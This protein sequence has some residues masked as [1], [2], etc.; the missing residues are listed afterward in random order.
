MQ[1][2]TMP[3]APESEIVAD[4]KCGGPDDG[5]SSNTAETLDLQANLRTVVG[6]ALYGLV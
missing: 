4:P 1:E 5:R 6:D 3:A 2:M